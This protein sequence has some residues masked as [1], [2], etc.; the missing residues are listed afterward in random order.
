MAC[1]F[2]TRLTGSKTDF[3]EKHN[4]SIYNLFCKL[5]EYISDPLPDSIIPAS[6]YWKTIDFEKTTSVESRA[7]HQESILPARAT[8]IPRSGNSPRTFVIWGGFVTQSG[9]PWNGNCTYEAFDIV[10]FQLFHSSVPT[11]VIVQFQLLKWK[12]VPKSA[13]PLQSHPG[14]VSDII[15]NNPANWT[16]TSPLNFIQHLQLHTAP[17]L[18][19]SQALKP[20]ATS[21]GT[22]TSKSKIK[23]M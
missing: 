11:F 23:A 3:K 21:D 2:Q 10:Q 14:I 15:L 12:D 4:K 5:F 1:G 18:G 8:T 13:P 7:H 22:P 16:V 20:T 9:S 6:V 19:T 17:K